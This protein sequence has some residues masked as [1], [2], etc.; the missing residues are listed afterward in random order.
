MPQRTMSYRA[1]GKAMAP[2]VLAAWS[3]APGP[4]G[5]SPATTSSKA[6][7]AQGEGAVLG[8]DRRRPPGGA[9]TRPRSGARSSAT[10]RDQRRHVGRVGAP[11]RCIPVST[12]T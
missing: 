9:S 11:T 6:R 7:A 5:P 10:A 12:F 8:V 1:A 4:A 3:R 2:A